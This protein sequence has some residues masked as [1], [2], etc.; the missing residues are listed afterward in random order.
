LAPCVWTA[1]NEVPKTFRRFQNNLIREIF[2][3]W[4]MPKD[5]VYFNEEFLIS[6]LKA[7]SPDAFKFVYDSRYRSLYHHV[8][9]FVKN[10]AVAE[11][12]IADT[13][14]VLWKSINEFASLKSIWKFTYVVAKNASLNHLKK[15][16]MVSRSGKELAYFA[17][18]AQKDAAINFLRQDLVQLSLIAA[19]NLPAKMKEVFQ[20]LYIEGFSMIETAEKLGLSVHTVR[21]QNRNSIIKIREILIKQGLLNALTLLAYLEVNR[22]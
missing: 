21:V 14:V 19:S 7:G 18:L 5:S 8:M 4:P 13:F 1:Y 15:V 9:C 16:K 20:L 10:S 12:I 22:N 2:Y 3:I 6:E 17:E 11:D